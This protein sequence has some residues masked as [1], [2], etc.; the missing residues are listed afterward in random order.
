LCARAGRRFRA[1]GQDEIL[2]WRE[3]LVEAVQ[4]P[5]EAIDVIFGDQRYTRHAEF[6]AE[7]EQL[8]LDAGQ[9]VAHGVR[10][11]GA[12]HQADRAVQLVDRAVGLDAQAVLVHARAVAEPGRALVAGAGVDFR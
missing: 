12:E 4:V 3:V 9:A 7:V 1:A 2:Q 8:V 5:F 10:Q 6:A 11:V